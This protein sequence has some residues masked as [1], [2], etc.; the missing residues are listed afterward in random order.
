MESMRKHWRTIHKWSQQTHRGRAGP[1]EKARG[2]A[3]LQQSFQY[4]SWQQVFPSG[5]GSH[6]IHIRYPDWVPL[7]PSMQGVQA[8]VNEVVQAWEQAQAQAKADQAIQASQLTDAN[9]WLRMT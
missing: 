4:V 9:P 3:E 5:L 8:A 6:Y 7:P 2:E 1:K